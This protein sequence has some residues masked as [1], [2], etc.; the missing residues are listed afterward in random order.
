MNYIDFVIILFLFIGFAL[1]FRDGLIRK[2][3]GLI[4]LVLGFIL[5]LEFYQR[6]AYLIAPFIN[7]E[8]YLAE[9]VAWL[10][11][12]IGT[13]FLASI[14][15]RIIHPLDKV[16]RFTN[17]LLGGISGTLQILFFISGFLLF[18]NVFEIPSKDI[19]ETSLLYSKAYNVIPYSIDLIIGENSEAMNLVKDFI[20][21]SSDIEDSK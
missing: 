14:L 19:Q 16:N 3:I 15:K 17:Q 9:I 11:I 2:L 1:G 6:V 7:N 12:F 21:K 20:E 10:F 4:G 13:I 8:I 5:A 18:L